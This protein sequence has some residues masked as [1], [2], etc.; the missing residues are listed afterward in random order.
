MRTW[1]QEAVMANMEISSELKHAL[2]AHER[3]PTFIDN[4]DQEVA[5]LQILRMKQGKPMYEEDQ[6]KWLITKMTDV[7][8]ASLEVEAQK[9][10]ESDL[11]RVLR[12]QKV[13]EEKAMDDAL[14]GNATG[15]Y[16]EMGVTA[17]DPV[18]TDTRVI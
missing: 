9:R 10:H 13:A 2:K 14:A 5:K 6:I 1:Y 18:S 12:E 4:M 17:S 3:V 8:V 7:F 16:Q 15:V 11:E